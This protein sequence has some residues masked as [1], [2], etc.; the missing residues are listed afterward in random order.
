MIICQTLQNSTDCR[1]LKKLKSSSGFALHRHQ[2][3]LMSKTL[4]KNFFFEHWYIGKE[5]FILDFLINCAWEGETIE[6]GE[7]WECLTFHPLIIVQMFYISC[8][9]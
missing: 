2:Q 6:S 5:C 3:L 4:V 1:V 9:C 8:Q 7:T